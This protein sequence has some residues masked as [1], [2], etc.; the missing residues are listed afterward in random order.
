MPA[1]LDRAKQ[2]ALPFAASVLIRA[3]RATVPIRFHN[4][5]ALERARGPSGRPYILS[6]WHG[7]LLLMRFAYPGRHITVLISRHRDGELIARTLAHFGI[8]STRGSTTS[9][10]M[11]GLREVV[12]RLREGWDAAFTPDG[13]RGPRH[14]V[15]PGVIEAARL[16][17]C[18]IVPVSFACRSGWRLNSWDRF[19]VPR[20]FTRGLVLYGEP[21]VV[22]ESARAGDLEAFRLRL[23]EDMVRLERESD[24]LVFRRRGLPQRGLP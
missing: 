13:P 11:A 23:Q 2:A 17:R 15:Q 1:P 9:G 6:F 10:G 14:V 20:P 19:V 18:A 22:P 24:D 8:H 4:A 21:M 5:G 7:R 16:S 3:L 12:R